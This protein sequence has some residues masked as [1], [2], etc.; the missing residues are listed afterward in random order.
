MDTYLPDEDAYAFNVIIYFIV[1]PERSISDSGNFNF[2]SIDEVLKGV[3]PR[4][5]VI[6]IS[7]PW[8]SMCIVLQVP[9]L[10]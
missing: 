9:I 2:I 1:S 10:S 5:F 6:L 3:F 7:H 4:G 8:M